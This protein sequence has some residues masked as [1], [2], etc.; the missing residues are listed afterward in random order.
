MDNRNIYVYLVAA[1][2]ALGGL[3]F[4]YDTGV[5]S[6]AILF[7]RQDFHLTHGQIEWIV[8]AVLLGCII[9]SAFGGRLADRFGRR[10][11]L[12]NR[13]FALYDC[14]FINSPRLQPHLACNWTPFYWN[15][16]W[17]LFHDHSS[18]YR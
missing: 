5:I 15:R 3:L 13:C 6:G 12:F 9:G 11:I 17:I 8:S 1:F 18:V 14:F 7:I 2:S 16:Y 10:R 4:G